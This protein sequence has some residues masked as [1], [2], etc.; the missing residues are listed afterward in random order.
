MYTYMFVHTYT[1]TC[2][3]HFCLVWINKKMEKVFQYTKQ[4]SSIDGGIIELPFGYDTQLLL[5][6]S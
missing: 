5:P 4:L 1:C 2:M 3:A 6:R